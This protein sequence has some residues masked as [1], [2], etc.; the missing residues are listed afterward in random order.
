MLTQHQPSQQ[1]ENHTKS[2]P[3]YWGSKPRFNLRTSPIW[4]GTSHSTV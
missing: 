2:Q 4:K 1:E 3:R